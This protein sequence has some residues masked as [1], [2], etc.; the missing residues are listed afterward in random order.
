MEQAIK[1]HFNKSIVQKIKQENCWKNVWIITLSDGQKIVFR[2][3]NI[4]LDLPKDIIKNANK[5][6]AEIYR[7]EKFFMII[8]IKKLEIYAPMYW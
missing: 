5:S 7:R 1:Y 4:R 8:S 3:H 6:M 2:S